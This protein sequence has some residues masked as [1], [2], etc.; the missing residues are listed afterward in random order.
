MAAGLESVAR[1]IAERMIEFSGAF[2]IVFSTNAVNAGKKV[3][4]RQP[5]RFESS[6]PP[7]FGATVAA[8]SDQFGGAARSS[9]RRD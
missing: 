3:G 6:R 4:G 8:Q 5:N 9:N 7:I 2:A 1:Y